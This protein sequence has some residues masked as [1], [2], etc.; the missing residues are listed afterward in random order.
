M[1]LVIGLTGGVASGKSTVEQAF[2]VRDVPVID[3]DQVARAVVAP[4]EPA[5]AAIRERFG[6]EVLQPD[7]SLDR[8]ALRAIV[9]SDGAARHDLEAITHP[10]IR[11]RLQGWRD[12]L[13]APYGVLSAATLVETG[14]SALCE[15]LL[16]VDVEPAKQ[17]ERVMARDGIDATMAD[18]MLAAQIDRQ[19]RLDA[20]H[21]VLHNTGSIAALEASVATLHAYYMALADGTAD[22]ER[23]W[24]LP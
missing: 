21:D 5:L 22:A 17:R 23:S 12:A 1:S 18:G 9:F 15:R 19:A 2:A 24:R 4:G 20:A 7:G 6:I 10:A 14:M 16:V 8:P 3:A 11:E 13:E